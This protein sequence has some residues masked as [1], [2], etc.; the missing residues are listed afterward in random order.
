MPYAILSALY[1]LTHL[2][3][4]IILKEQKV[5]LLFPFYMCGN[6]GT[7]S[8]SNLPNLLLMELIM[9]RS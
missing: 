8:L 6:W 9:L 2:I 7:D 3:L 4:T 1:I 5:L